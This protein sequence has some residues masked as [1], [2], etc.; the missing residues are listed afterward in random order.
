MA[1]NHKPIAHSRKTHIAL[2]DP[3]ISSPMR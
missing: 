1:A 2:G 3:Q